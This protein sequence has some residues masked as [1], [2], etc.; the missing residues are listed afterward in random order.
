MRVAGQN[1][2]STLPGYTGEESGDSEMTW[3]WDSL[4]FL[5]PTQNTAHWLQKKSGVQLHPLRVQLQKILSRKNRSSRK[6][7]RK[8]NSERKEE[9]NQG[10]WVGSA[11]P[12]GGVS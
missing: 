1:T 12:S 5:P 7:K 3:D 10:Q 2:P 6:A 9:K 11:V 4:L 8:K